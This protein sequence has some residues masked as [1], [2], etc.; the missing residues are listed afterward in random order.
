M[1]HR[2]HGERFPKHSMKSWCGSPGRVARSLYRAIIRAKQ[3]ET[4][5]RDPEDAAVKEER[6]IK[7]LSYW[8]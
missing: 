6:K 1:G 8:F 7:P 5:R 3:R 2:F 4:F